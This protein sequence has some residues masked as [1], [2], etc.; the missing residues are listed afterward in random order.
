[1]VPPNVAIRKVV[2]VLNGHDPVLRRWSVGYLC[3]ALRYLGLDAKIVDLAKEHER[4]CDG[5]D[6]VVVYRCFDLR[7][8]RV[9]HR[10]RIQGSF[11]VYFLDDYLFQ[12][13]CVYTGGRPFTTV[14]ME[15]ADALMSSSAELLRR[16]PFDKPKILRR[17]VLDAEAMGLLRQ[18][19]RRTGVFSVGWPAG[20]GRGT[21]MDGFIH[22]FLKELEGMLTGDE[23]CVFHCFGRQVFEGGKRVVVGQNVYFGCK[24]WKGFYSKMKSFDLGAVINPLD[25]KDEFWWCK[26]ELKFVEAGAMGVPLVTS[27]VPP[28]LGLIQEGV[29]G[30]LASTP[31]EFAAKVV[32]LLR[33]EVMSHRVSAEAY[34]TVKEGYDV[35][36]NAQKFLVDV[37]AARAR[38]MR[39]VVA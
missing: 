1:M 14:P 24:D 32:S 37:A 3:E 5:A 36:R 2:F 19:Y 30:F 13:D 16:M 8:I 10:V 38:L 4:N 20:A 18:E 28:Y 39:G 35:I 23:R 27:R 17:S 15:E 22:G 9:M 25:E 29:N 12:P 6:L 11:V 33:D 7:T 34:R 26:S 31:A 21:R